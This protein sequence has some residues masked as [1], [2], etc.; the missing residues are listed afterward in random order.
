MNLTIDLMAPAF[1]SRREF[2]INISPL[3]RVG[4]IS[5]IGDAVGL[6]ASESSRWISGQ[7]VYVAG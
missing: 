6:F 5:D 1:E 3:K 4:T 7:A 2:F